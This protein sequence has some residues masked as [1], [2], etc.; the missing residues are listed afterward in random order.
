MILNVHYYVIY[1]S[2]QG[3]L[4]LSTYSSVIAMYGL[5]LTI[6]QSLLC[7]Y[8]TVTYSNCLLLFWYYSLISCRAFG[9]FKP[10]H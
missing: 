10:S 7:S 6:V 5:I 3:Y 4:T 1:S 2:L 9:C 8:F